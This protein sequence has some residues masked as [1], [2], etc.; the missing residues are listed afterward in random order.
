MP[1]ETEGL[2]ENLKALEL[3]PNKVDLTLYE[4]PITNHW[5]G[6]MRNAFETR[7]NGR[8]GRHALR[9]S[10]RF[11][12][13]V[14]REGDGDFYSEFRHNSFTLGSKR[15]YAEFLEN[16]HRMQPVIRELLSFPEDD[17]GLLF[18]QELEDAVRGL[19]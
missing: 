16:N 14:T 12:D 13:S 10:G 3:S 1:F 2:D 5:R 7:G 8:W 18:A 6:H 17:P 4:K 15:H 11:R 19:F 9:K